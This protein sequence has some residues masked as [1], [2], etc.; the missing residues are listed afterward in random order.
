MRNKV[1]LF[2]FFIGMI[3]MQQDLLLAASGKYLIV[4]QAGKGTHEGLARAVH[5]LLYTKE[6]REHGYEVKLVFDGAGTEWVAEW[7]NPESTDRLKGRYEALMKDGVV[8]LICD[9]CASAFKVNKE[10][11]ERN[12]TLTDEYEGHPSI[13]K[14]ADQGYQFIVL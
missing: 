10:L 2:L 1:M 3:V 6:L 12:V 5:A 14:W 7:T 13:A 11:K 9:F 8:Q 4:L